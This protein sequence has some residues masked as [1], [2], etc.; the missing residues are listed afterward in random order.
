MI[1]DFGFGKNSIEDLC[2]SWLSGKAELVFHLAE[3]DCRYKL[4]AESKTNPPPTMFS[5]AIEGY[6]EVL[7]MVTHTDKPLNK[8]NRTDKS[9]LSVEG[10]HLPLRYP[11]LSRQISTPLNHESGI[12][13]EKALAAPSFS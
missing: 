9:K 6:P 11:H 3:P 12:P 4:L 13:D 7:Q 2:R 1:S 5:F 10:F 8:S